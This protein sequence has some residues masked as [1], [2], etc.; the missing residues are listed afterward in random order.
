MLVW[1]VSVTKPFVVIPSASFHCTFYWRK[2]VHPLLNLHY[3]KHTKGTNIWF[4]ATQNLVSDLKS[5]LSHPK[6]IKVIGQR[7]LLIEISKEVRSNH[8]STI[9]GSWEQENTQYGALSIFYSFCFSHCLFMVGVQPS[10]SMS[11]GCVMPLRRD[12]V[13]SAM[14]AQD[15]WAE[16]D[17]SGKSLLILRH[18][19]EM[20]LGHKEDKPWDSFILP[21]SC[22]DLGH[23][24]DRQWDSFILPLSYCDFSLHLS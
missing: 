20:N 9:K 19:W 8:S 14:L 2:S 13:I 10:F 22:H 21:L 7:E 12:C 16:C 1:F 11:T 18:G 17:E 4:L 24:K 15:G 23:G 3:L 6:E 5:N